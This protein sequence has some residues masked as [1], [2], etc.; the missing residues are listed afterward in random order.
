M[1][2]K[3]GE[4]GLIIPK[5]LLKGIKEVEIKEQDGILA[6]IPI[7]KEDPIFSLGT[8][9]IEDSV[10]DASINHDRYLDP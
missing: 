4:Q 8:Q 1:K 10:T 6:I 5:Q 9:P 7:D 2:V 3:V